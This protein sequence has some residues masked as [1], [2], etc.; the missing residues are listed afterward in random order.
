[1]KTLKQK[2]DY[3]LETSKEYFNNYKK[4]RIN[5]LIRK[6]KF[7]HEISSFINKCTHNSKRSLFFCCG[8]SILADNIK[9][10][11]KFIHEID[12]DYLKQKKIKVLTIDINKSCVR[13]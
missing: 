10:K 7:F 13:L 9:S 3:F 12:Y 1:M 6:K 2:K 8:N 5:F 11:E 4:S